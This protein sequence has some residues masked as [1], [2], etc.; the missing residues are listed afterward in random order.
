MKGTAARFNKLFCQ[1]RFSWMNALL[2]L[3]SMDVKVRIGRKRGRGTEGK[4]R[5]KKDNKLIINL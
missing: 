2:F 5:E 1:K 4:G 3:L